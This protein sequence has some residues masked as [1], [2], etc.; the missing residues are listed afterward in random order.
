[1]TPVRVRDFV[2]EDA[3]RWEEFVKHCGEATFFHRAGWKE[4][5]ERSFGHGCHFLQARSGAR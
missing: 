2:P 5:I 3:A 1:V 4:V